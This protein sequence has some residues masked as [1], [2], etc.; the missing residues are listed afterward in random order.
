MRIQWTNSNTSQPPAIK[1]ANV[2]IILRFLSLPIRESGGYFFPFFREDDLFAGFTLF[3]HFVG[4]KNIKKHRS[5]SNWIES[6]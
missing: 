1:A 3:P 5:V 4:K 2:S 6:D